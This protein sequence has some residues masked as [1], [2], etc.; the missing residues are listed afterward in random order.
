MSD[1]RQHHHVTLVP[2]GDKVEQT[3]DLLVQCAERV[4]AKPGQGPT[5]WCASYDADQGC[6]YVE[7]L[8]PDDTAVAFHQGNIQDLVAQFGALMAARP[9]TIIR[10]VFTIA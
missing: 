6:F 5:S 2:Q 3:R 7:A 1:T 10:P 8:F 9:E 4:K